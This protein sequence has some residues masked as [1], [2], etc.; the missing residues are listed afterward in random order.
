[1]ILPKVEQLDALLDQCATLCVCVCGGGGVSILL[2]I[3]KHISHKMATDSHVMRQFLSHYTNGTGT[4]PTTCK[5][6]LINLVLE[7]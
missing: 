5:L 1:M 4:Y 3:Y 2:Y 6:K 7:L